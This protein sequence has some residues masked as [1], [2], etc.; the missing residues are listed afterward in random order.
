MLQTKHSKGW[1]NSIRHNLSLN[2]C[3]VKVTSLP[4]VIALVMLMNL[5]FFISDV[6]K[7]SIV[8]SPNL[9]E[10]QNGFLRFQVKGGRRGRETT[11]A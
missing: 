10:F 2:E 7:T 1:Q 9:S 3:F 5:D 6:T 11:G 4:I 8:S